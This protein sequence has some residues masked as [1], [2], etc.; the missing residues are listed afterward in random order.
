MA[1]DRQVRGPVRRKVA[2]AADGVNLTAAA[3]RDGL[4]LEIEV[5]LAKILK[6]LGLTALAA[7]LPPGLTKIPARILIDPSYVAQPKG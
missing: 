6:S 1:R 7:K 5:D 3:F 2:A 4:A